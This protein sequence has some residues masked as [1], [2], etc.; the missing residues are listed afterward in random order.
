[1][2]TVFEQIIEIGE[3]TFPVAWK[4]IQERVTAGD[5]HKAI[6]D[7]LRQALGSRRMSAEYWQWVK[8]A[9]TAAA[10]KNNIE[11]LARRRQL[12][13]VMGGNLNRG[14]TTTH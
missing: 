2:K 10:H 11:A 12:R 3:K 1:M 5:D 4:F 13:L 9:T 7:A 8:D 6:A 14:T